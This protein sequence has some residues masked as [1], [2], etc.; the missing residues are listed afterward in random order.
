VY[1]VSPLFE[2][3]GAKFVPVEDQEFTQAETAAGY[4]TPSLRD[5]GVHGHAHEIG[6]EARGLY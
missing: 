4:A 3:L 6:V 2:S 1:S 5:W